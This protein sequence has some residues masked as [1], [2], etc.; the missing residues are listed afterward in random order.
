MKKFILPLLCFMALVVTA[1]E[2]PT[3][4]VTGYATLNREIT[5]YRAQVT[6]NL[7]QRFYQDRTYG[8]VAELQAA[9]L[10]KVRQVGL[11]TAQF[12]EDR[13]ANGGYPSADTTILIFETEDQQALLTLVDLKFAG[14]NIYNIE[15]KTRLG[16]TGYAQLVKTAHG[17]A[18]KKGTDLAKAMGKQLGAIKSM[19]N[20]TDIGERWYSYNSRTEIFSL[21]VTYW[22]E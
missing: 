7:E 2:L 20:R 9:Y 22:V 5:A 1:Q 12:R 11:D 18:Q 3:V 10:E 4:S 21:E 8:T 14:A 19:G 15:A 13:F 17:D 16:D 6:I